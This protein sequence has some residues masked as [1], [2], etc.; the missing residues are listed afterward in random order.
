MTKNLYI[1]ELSRNVFLFCPGVPVTRL[2][3]DFEVE[4]GK[5]EIKAPVIS[6]NLLELWESWRYMSGGG[7]GEL[8]GRERTI[9]PC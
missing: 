5:T 4:S 1:L 7:T 2:I 3:P 6:C 9:P 8:T